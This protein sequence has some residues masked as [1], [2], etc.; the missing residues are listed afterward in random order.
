MSYEPRG[1]GVAIEIVPKFRISGFLRD[2]A[3]RPYN[4]SV[5]QISR[6]AVPLGCH[7]VASGTGE[8]DAIHTQTHV[9]VS[10][11]RFTSPSVAWSLYI[12]HILHKKKEA[13]KSVTP[14]HQRSKLLS[15]I[16]LFIYFLVRTT[17]NTWLHGRCF[18]KRRD[19][20]FRVKTFSEGQFQYV[21]CS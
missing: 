21:Q 12:L 1:W 3:W 7:T 15:L 6:C 11:F 10:R 14:S 18:C 9:V 8:S 5:D 17:Q 4:W 13:P 19:V 20:K 2:Q 16:Y